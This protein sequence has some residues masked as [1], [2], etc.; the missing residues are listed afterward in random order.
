MTVNQKVHG[1]VEEIPTREWM[2]TAT[3][4]AAGAGIICEEARVGDVARR[5]RRQ[6]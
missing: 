2:Y 1:F 6:V 5:R 3:A 4:T